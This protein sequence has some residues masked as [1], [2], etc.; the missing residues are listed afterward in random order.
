MPVEVRHGGKQSPSGSAFARSAAVLIQGAV[1]EVSTKKV[2]SLLEIRELI[3]GKASQRFSLLV[4]RFI[5][6]GKHAGR[7]QG[8]TA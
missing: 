4:C 3:F 7:Q 8:P 2:T 6:S 1:A 5:T